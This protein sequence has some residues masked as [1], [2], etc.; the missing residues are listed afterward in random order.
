[1]THTLGGGEAQDLAVVPEQEE[2]R[3]CPHVGKG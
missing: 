3:V 2:G 1:M